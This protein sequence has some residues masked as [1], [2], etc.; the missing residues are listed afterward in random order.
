MRNSD[1]LKNLG[2]ISVVLCTILLLQPYSYGK[3][4]YG[5]PNDY[6]QYG[7]GGRA[8]AMGGAY[9]ALAD[10]ATSPYWNPACL[11]R[12][13][14]HQLYTM[15]APFF[16]DT[17]FNFL[18]YAHPLGPDGTLSVSDT[19]LHSS[20]FE[21]R[22]IHNVVESSDESILH[23]TLSLSYGLKLRDVRLPFNQYISFACGTSLKMVQE[24]DMGYSGTGYGCDLG[25]LFYPLDYLSWGISFSN[26]L[27]PRV[28]LI[29]DS[30][31]Y[32]TNIKTGFALRAASDRLTLTTDINKLQKEKAYFC[33]G[34]EFIP[35]EEISVR[36]GYNH[37]QDFT[38]GFGLESQKHLPLAFDYA[39]STNDL[40][41]LHRF[42]VNF[43][44]GN[45]YSAKIQPVTK[46]GETVALK[47]LLNELE[48]ET[49]MPPFAVKNWEL[50]ITDAEGNI[51]KTFEGATR[52]P[53]KIR[54]D[55]HDKLGRPMKRG[56]YN[57][58][59]NI[60]YEND[61]IWEDRGKINI[62]FP[63]L[64]QDKPEKVKLEIKNLKR[65]EGDEEG[66]IEVKKEE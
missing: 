14:E 48:L 62:E 59:L 54:W 49:N 18:S 66:E 11:E 56:M 39:Y 21:K 55:V 52:P 41:S 19:L 17:S 38:C 16:F 61:R 51:H 2:L 7:V 43:K 9:V 12:I 24:K 3:N 63:E 28:T 53:Q 27:K 65:E 47:G 4:Y 37:L 60:T 57:Y 35:I 29:E 25:L 22:S 64:I 44:W 15:Y 26:L 5:L 8:L 45:I 42:S 30:N 23:H 58:T 36:M 46:T 50:K 31:I 34:I 40:G 10:D 1:Y 33:A 6:L 32:G 13:D 20:G